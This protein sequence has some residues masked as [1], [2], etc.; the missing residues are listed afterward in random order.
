MNRLIQIILILTKLFQRIFFFFFFNNNSAAFDDFGGNAEDDGGFNT[1]W[2]YENSG[3]KDE[4]NFYTGHR[5]ITQLTGTMSSILFGNFFIIFYISCFFENFRKLPGNSFFFFPSSLYKTHLIETLWDRRL[6]G[7]SVWLVEV[8][9]VLLLFY[10][11]L[12]ILY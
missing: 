3:K 4:R 8:R 7:D 9:L 6:V 2:E 1:F 12:C 11:C 10:C 5:L